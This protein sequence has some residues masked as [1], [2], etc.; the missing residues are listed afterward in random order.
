MIVTVQ[1]LVDVDADDEAEAESYVRDALYDVN[2]DGHIELGAYGFDYIE[3]EVK[4]T[5]RC[6]YTH[7]HTRAWCGVPTCREA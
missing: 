3:G 2:R 1:M 7:S 6:P 4:P 5:E